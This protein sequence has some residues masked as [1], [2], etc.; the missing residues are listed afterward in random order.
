MTSV[1]QNWVTPTQPQ[2]QQQLT[3]QTLSNQ[4]GLGTTMAGVT[5]AASFGTAKQAG[6]DGNPD[7][8]KIDT[9]DVGVSYSVDDQ[10]ASTLLSQ[11]QK[12]D[13]FKR[14]RQN[15]KRHF[16][17]DIYIAPGVSTLRNCFF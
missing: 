7:T 5:L 11:T 16:R 1:S 17:L 2:I 3:V 4:F 14:W 8:S 9:R 6:A 12:K 13:R 10:Q 15:V